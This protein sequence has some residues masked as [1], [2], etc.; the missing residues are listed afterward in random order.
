MTMNLGQLLERVNGFFSKEENPKAYRALLG[1]VEK[2]CAAIKEELGEGVV[3]RIYGRADKQSDHDLFKS[4][5]KIAIALSRTPDPAKAQIEDIAD[6]VGLTIVVHYPDQ[7]EA[8]VEELNRRLSAPERIVAAP[9]KPMSSRGYYA[10]HVV[11]TSNHQDHRRKKCEVQIKTVLHDAWGAKT[12][13]LTY[14]PKGPFDERFEKMMQVFGDALQAIDKQSEVLRELIEERWRAEHE[15]KKIVRQAL[16]Q[17]LPNWQVHGGSARKIRERIDSRLDHFRSCSSNDPDIQS[18]LA[19][20]AELSEV[21]EAYLLEAFL[22]I[23]RD[24]RLEL[25]KAVSRSELWLSACED[26][27]VAEAT[28]PIEIWSTPLVMQACDHIDAA[29]EAGERLLSGA[30]AFAAED[31]E[32]VSVNLANHIIEREYFKPSA[33]KLQRDETSRRIS[34][35]LQSAPILRSKD[36]SVFLDTEG[37]RDIVF[38]D[39]ARVIRKAIDRIAEGKATAA[40]DD[41]QIAEAYFE[42]NCRIGWRRLLDVEARKRGNT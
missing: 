13:D 18:I 22:A 42:L 8:V 21:R 17:S 40:A 5:E 2:H 24:R 26:R 37:M 10:T 25:R 7:I 6:I 41:A 28:N 9:A 15:W 35:L 27:Q 23:E 4:R 16:L 39:D 32:V 20:I 3:Y 38:S 33:S 14:K 12:H 1:I 31:R 36:P 34:D 30:I 29:I 19:E 11:F